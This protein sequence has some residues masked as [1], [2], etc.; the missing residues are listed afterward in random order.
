MS[1]TQGHKRATAFSGNSAH[2]S[3]E[4]FLAHAVA[5]ESEVAERY[6]EIAD[7]MEVH[8][9]HEVAELFRKLADASQKHAAEMKTRTEGKILPKIAPWDFQWGD[10]EAPETPS[11][12][13]THYLMT[14]YHALDLARDAEIQ[15]QNYYTSVADNTPNPQV[16]NL[17]LE[18]AYEEA[19]H[20]DMVNNLIARYPE[21]EDG[22]DMDLDPPANPA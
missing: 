17:A 7:S 15:A 10:V 9:N 4:E 12:G 11:M 2:K 5:L 8:N 16:R 20:V 18:F 1:P 21:P 13:A 14:A 3:V 6:A 22:W 19:E